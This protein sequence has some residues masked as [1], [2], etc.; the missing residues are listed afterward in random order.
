MRRRIHRSRGSLRSG[1]C[2]GDDNADY[3]AL[4]DRRLL[5]V[6]LFVVFAMALSIILLELFG[7][8]KMLPA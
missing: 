1:L 6:V 8:D 5:L 4:G 3:L 2:V 7:A